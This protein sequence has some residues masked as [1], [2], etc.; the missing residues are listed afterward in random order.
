M[1]TPRLVCAAPQCLLTD[2]SARDLDAEAAVGVLLAPQDGVV[3]GLDT[4]LPVGAR[5]PDRRQDAE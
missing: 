2:S 3:L 4:V 5:L 1:F